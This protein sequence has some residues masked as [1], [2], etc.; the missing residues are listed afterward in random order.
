MPYDE[1]SFLQ[2]IMI[3]RTLRGYLALDS[4]IINQNTNQPSCWNEEGIYSYFYIQ[5][6]QPINT[7]TKGQ[8]TACHS[9]FSQNGELS[10]T[11][12]QIIDESTIKIVCDI[13]EKSIDQQSILLFSASS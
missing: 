9:I 3:G 13:A 7:I 5:Y 8:F 2:G 4:T 6:P 11:N 1:N 12:I 10:I